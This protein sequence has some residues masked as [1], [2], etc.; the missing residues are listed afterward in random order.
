MYK[1][2][3][4]LYAKKEQ[5]TIGKNI[6]QDC[7]KI[8]FKHCNFID[9]VKV[10]G[11][12]GNVYICEKCEIAKFMN[13][14]IEGT[15]SN[16]DILNYIENNECGLLITGGEP[17]YGPNLVQTLSIINYINDKKCPFI[18]V[19]TNGY[20]LKRL[21]CGIHSKNNVNIYLSPNFIDSD[22]FDYYIR[23]FSS[24]KVLP[25]NIKLHLLDY[26]HE[27]DDEYN[28]Q[29]KKLEDFL[30]DNKFI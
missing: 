1:S 16:L 20:H 14:Y 22:N 10:D 6:G 24:I 5:R 19:E 23:S 29:F 28:I 11:S 15:T 26:K 9:G 7:L 27:E 12:E 21:I 18:D 8:L 4:C 13:D 30:L 25:D 17:T 2:I 3:R